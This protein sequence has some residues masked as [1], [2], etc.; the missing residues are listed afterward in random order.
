[1]APDSLHAL[2][3]ALHDRDDDANRRR[4]FEQLK[5][6]GQVLVPALVA[7][8]GEPD[9]EVRDRATGA[10]SWLG[11][12]AAAAVAPLAAV[13]LNEKEEPR[14]RERARIALASIGEAS[15]PHLMEALR[16]PGSYVR[17]EAAAA[18]RHMR[19]AP[20]PLAVPAL[21]AALGD[22]EQRVRTSAAETLADMGGPAQP[23]L[24]DALAAPDLCTRVYAAHALLEG[25]FGGS[26]NRTP[27]VP[28]GDVPA[29]LVQLGQEDRAA[30]IANLIEGLRRGDPEVRLDC[31]GFLS[32]PRPGYRV[33]APA[34]LEAL[35]DEDYHVRD[36]ATTVIA[37]VD[38]TLPGLLPALRAAVRDPDEGIRF[39]AM[40]SLKK[41]GSASSAA[42]PEL[43]ALL[44][45]EPPNSWLLGPAAGVLE[46]M[47]PAAAPALPAFR[48][49]VAQYTNAEG[50][51]SMRRSLERIQRAAGD[52]A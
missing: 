9:S 52:E 48:R 39:S 19:F 7:A 47:G 23:A 35:H 31:V 10:L 43:I 38:P 37:E 5:K 3:A 14:V 8:L 27:Y 29:P 40:C 46:A 36:L 50:L 28:P 45:A 24:L 15:V 49:A 11:A 51:D 12:D 13:F 2:L 44:E 34:L 1:M 25:A 33:A 26:R 16:H 4:A 32:R 6:A 22:T 30:A 21:V 17:C 41:L 18:F 20:P 42:L